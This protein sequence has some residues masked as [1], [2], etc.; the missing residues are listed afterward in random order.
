MLYG[1]TFHFTEEAREKLLKYSER[2]LGRHSQLLEAFEARDGKRARRVVK[3]YMQEV[4]E[5]SKRFLQRSDQHDENS[6]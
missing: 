4:W 1:W 3:T 2:D 6:K 5:S